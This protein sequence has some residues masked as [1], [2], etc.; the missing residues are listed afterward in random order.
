M[1]THAEFMQDRDDNPHCLLPG[2]HVL[3]I[4][5]D[6]MHIVS[7]G[8]YHWL[9]GSAIWAIILLGRWGDESTPWKRCRA[10]QLR[11]TTT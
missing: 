9:C 2:F 3:S 8:V 6:F 7:L 5:L 11:T 1:V 10:K 4:R